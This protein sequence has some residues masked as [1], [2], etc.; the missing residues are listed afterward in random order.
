MIKGVIGG[1]YN[2]FD[3][4]VGETGEWTDEEIKAYASWDGKALVCFAL[5]GLSAF[6]ALVR[7]FFES[8]EYSDKIKT[9]WTSFNAQYSAVLLFGS[10]FLTEEIIYNTID[11]AIEPNSKEYIRS[12]LGHPLFS[13]RMV[14]KIFDHP[15]LEVRTMVFILSLLS[16]SV[17]VTP[18]MVRAF[19]VKVSEYGGNADHDYSEALSE[20]PAAIE[21]LKGMASH[22]RR[23]DQSYAGLPDDW[24][25]DIFS[26]YVA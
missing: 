12:L 1:G 14:E 4:E 11:S 9:I 21:A 2:N 13:S 20:Y 16:D 6:G 3:T 15:R 5:D 26:G 7:I 18:S 8:S 10:D 22:V 23:L 24:V 19:R 25:L 17:T